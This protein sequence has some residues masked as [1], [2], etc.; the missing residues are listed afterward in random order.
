MIN[1]EELKNAVKE[2]FKSL[3]QQDVDRWDILSISVDL[4]R[5][6]DDLD[7]NMWNPVTESVPTDERYILLHF[8]N[9]SLPSIG[10]YQEDENGGA[11][12]VGDDDDPCVKYGLF[13]NA[14][15]DLPERYKGEE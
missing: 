15:M 12:Y 14:W 7:K 10:R 1:A 8:E 9:F 6:I 13:V 11:F 5:I 3:V 2:Y 4:Q